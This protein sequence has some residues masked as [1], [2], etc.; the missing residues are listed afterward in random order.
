ML[1]Q[2]ASSSEEI[3]AYKSE[4]SNLRTDLEVSRQT[5][6]QLNTLKASMEALEIEH[7][8]ANTESE[9]K[10][11]LFTSELADVKSN[12]EQITKEKL[13]REDELN[14]VKE[15]LVIL[16]EKSGDEYS[17]VVKE[18]DEAVKQVA[19]LTEQFQLEKQVRNVKYTLIVVCI[20]CSVD[21]CE[22]L[23]TSAVDHCK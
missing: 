1:Q 14:R 15:E 9:E 7:K 13:L 23:T 8:T 12:L 17:I 10:I 19:I 21:R 11:N 3:E 16:R 5:E 20:R 2:S 18:K 4:I 6:L 22:I